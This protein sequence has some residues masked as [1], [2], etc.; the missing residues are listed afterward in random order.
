MND[1]W[2][3]IAGY[4][5]IGRRH[6]QNLGQLGWSDVRLL[7]KASARPGS[8]PTPEGTRVYSELS[9][10]LADKPFAVIVANPT[11]LHVPVTRESLLAGSHVLLEKPVCDRLADAE[12][13]LSVCEHTSSVCSMAYCFRY[14][15]LYRAAKEL[16]A[17]GRL[18]RVFHMKTW[19]AS[20]LPGWHP[21]EDYRESYA[22]RADMGG[23]VVRTLD[24]ELD[25]LHWI[26]G[27][28]TSVLASAHQLSSLD[29][30]VEDTADMI[31]GFDDNRQANIHVSYACHGGFRGMLLVGEKATATL[32]WG[33]GSL[34]CTDSETPIVKLAADFDLNTVYEEM[35]REALDGFAASSPV[36][37]ICLSSGVQSLRMATAV[38]ESSSLRACKDV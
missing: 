37:A 32:D 1:R 17:S 4:G 18:G 21:W 35:L 31:F 16:A 28:P 30:Q 8:F 25:M 23:G 10:A 22:A 7:R 19:Q 9:Q 15:P 3:L 2:I 33:A 29:I 13:L 6:F 12:E 11:A 20:Y 5:S 38:L 36:A 34:T 27:P 24:H 26:M 14:H